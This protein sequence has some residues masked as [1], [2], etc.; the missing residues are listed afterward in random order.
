MTRSV[1]NNVTPFGLCSTKMQEEFR[2][3]RDA[4]HKIIMYEMDG[5]WV[6]VNARSFVLSK[7]YRVKAVE[8][9]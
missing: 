6:N 8:V 2:T 9:K 1:Y 3:M 4:G 7:V 5:E